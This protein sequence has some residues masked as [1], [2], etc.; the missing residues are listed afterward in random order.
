MPGTLLCIF[1]VA[2]SSPELRKRDSKPPHPAP[3]L[4]TKKLLTRQYVQSVK[5]NIGCANSMVRRTL[6]MVRHGQGLVVVCM[7][8][9]GTLSSRQAH[10]PSKIDLV[11]QTQTESIYIMS[12]SHPLSHLRTTPTITFALHQ[13]V[14]IN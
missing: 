14:P 4:P 5:G 2:A 8:T 1:L 9:K 7:Y 6:V 3:S 12:I 10:T 13:P 11:T